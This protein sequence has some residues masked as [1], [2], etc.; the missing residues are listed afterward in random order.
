MATITSAQSGNWGTTTTWVGGVIP[1]NGD[2]V[3]IPAG[4]YVKVDV[5]ESGFAAGLN[6][7]TIDGTVHFSPS[8]V[9]ALKINGNLSGT[10]RY[11]QAYRKTVS[12][13]MTLVE[14]KTNTWARLIGD[15]AVDM[16]QLSDLRQMTEL[17]SIED[18]EETPYSYYSDG[19]NIYVHLDGTDPTGKIEY[20]IKINRPEVN[21][22]SRSQL[23]MNA[24]GI[25]TV[26]RITM[27]GW[28]HE[29]EFATI[30]EDAAA[31][32]NI[33][34]LSADLGFQAGDI[35]Q[36]T[37]INVIGVLTEPTK[38]IYTVSAYDSITKTITLS[39][40]LGGNRVV[41]DYVSWVSRPIKISRTT[42]TAALLAGDVDYKLKLIGM[43]NTMSLMSSSP[44]IF[45][46]N[47][48]VKHC[49]PRNGRVLLLYTQ[50][51][52]IEDCVSSETPNGSIGH[53]G[54]GILR[55]C[56]GMATPISYGIHEV[57]DSVQ[58]NTNS[59]S[60]G[61]INKNCIFH[62]QLL[63]TSKNVKFIDS[64]IKLYDVNTNLKNIYY[65]STIE[66]INCEII[67]LN[68]NSNLIPYGNLK[69][70]NTLVND[71]FSILTPDI[72]VESFN[73]NQINGN[74]KKWMFG[75][76]IE[77]EHVGEVYTPDKLVFICESDDYPVYRDYP[78]LVPAN[79]EV[80][81]PIGLIKDTADIICKLQVIEPSSDPLIDSSFV[82][83]A[84]ST[85]ENSII[86]QDLGIPY[87]SEVPRQLIL[88]V[89]CQGLGNVTVDTSS[90]DNVLSHPVNY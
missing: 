83:L 31:G 52:L 73:H 35:I 61:K 13:Q 77:T 48:I 76:R 15:I 54:Y 14:G 68:P 19:T 7:I 26:P 43:Q 21:N 72:I 34:Q 88:R 62:A 67:N 50:N 47:P 39:A 59:I 16:Y 69:L 55:R 3:I 84:E 32:T 2:T 20:Y 41:G 75:G 49:T 66:F 38:G 79:R 81:F 89:F 17:F 6:G 4:I 45:V 86:N 74:Y 82:P 70:N 36:I 71:D 30:A 12:T 1:A 24:T 46:N 85:A 33:I 44:T 25:I 57:H 78:I 10:G 37:S 27:A 65:N 60:G 9:T 40:N 64:I 58:M 90:I 28:Y 42:G 18:V 80:K 8:T 53:Y 56:F 63:N 11:I 29:L 23:I 87:K 22:E 5:D 51:F